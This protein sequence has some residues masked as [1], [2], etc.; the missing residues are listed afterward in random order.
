MK[1]YYCSAMLC[2][3]SDLYKSKSQPIVW[4]NNFKNLEK[5][6]L[7]RTDNCANNGESCEESGKE[8]SDENSNEINGEY[9]LSSSDCVVNA[10]EDT[11]TD[12]Y[13]EVGFESQTVEG[14]DSSQQ[15]FQE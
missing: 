1:E 3:M 10:D 4:E 14:V 7:G 2:E 13:T 9:G 6:L 11:A 8:L 12:S 15:D 5:Q